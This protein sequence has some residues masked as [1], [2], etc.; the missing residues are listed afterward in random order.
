MGGLSEGGGVCICMSA[1]TYGSI[2]GLLIIKPLVG[3]VN[4]AF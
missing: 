4:Q 1:N 3:E 2:E